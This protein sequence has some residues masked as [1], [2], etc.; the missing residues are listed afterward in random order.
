MMLGSH[1]LFFAPS[2]LRRNLGCTVLTVG[3]LVI[4][5]T[6]E[7]LL[8]AVF[9]ALFFVA[10]AVIDR[11][12]TVLFGLV[13]GVTMLLFSSII[14]WAIFS[15]LATV[16]A[17]IYGNSV[18]PAVRLKATLASM[19]TFGTVV[20][21]IA[22]L[23]IAVVARLIWRYRKRLSKVEIVG[24]LGTLC[25]T[26]GLFI[27]QEIS[28]SGAL[29]TG[30]R[31]DFPAMLLPIFSVCFIACGVSLR[32]RETG[33]ETSAD[34]RALFFAAAVVT[35]F[36][37]VGGIRGAAKFVDDVEANIV[38]T[39]EFSVEIAAI[40]SR[41]R[42]NPAAPIILEAYGGEAY[43]PVYS[44][45]RYL[46]SEGLQN[47]IAVRLHPDER[48]SGPLYEN[49]ERSLR[50]L[51]DTG[52]RSFTRLADVPAVAA[53]LSIGINGDA[54]TRCYGFKVRT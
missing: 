21:C 13:S 6:K 11:R 42:T 43:E 54:D 48:S 32:L 53:C 45:Q 10:L 16:G 50:T 28:Y 33:R 38:R 41:A 27:S 7:T 25:F 1:E 23:T 47:P 35:I 40:V 51:Q 49:L 30:T 3:T 39:K 26:L 34:G 20:I 14:A 36:L 4:I 44:L 46:L 18:S 37:S 8:P 52:G 19:R 29:P 31:Y 12:L 24:G 2:V 9:L 5:G 17:D 15:Q 22:V